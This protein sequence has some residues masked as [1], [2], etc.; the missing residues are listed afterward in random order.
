MKQKVPPGLW[1]YGLIY[2]TNTLNRIPR[3][4]QLVPALRLSL[5]RHQIYPSGLT[6]SFMIACGIMIRRKLRSTEVDDVSHDGA[7]SHNEL[8]A[9]FVIGCYLS[10]A[11]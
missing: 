9:T 5:V 1:D 10:L 6:L 7:V 4:Q 3:G 8:D 11:K 2:E